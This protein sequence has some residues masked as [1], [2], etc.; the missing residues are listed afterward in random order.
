LKRSLINIFSS[1]DSKNAA[2]GL[3]MVSIFEEV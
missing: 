1:D 3:A 2:V